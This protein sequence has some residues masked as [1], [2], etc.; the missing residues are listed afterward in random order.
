[1][2]Q[3]Q[4]VKRQ[5]SSSKGKLTTW[6]SALVKQAKRPVTRAPYPS[7]D[8]AKGVVTDSGCPGWKE[9]DARQTDEQSRHQE[10]ALARPKVRQHQQP[11]AKTCQKPAPA[12]NAPPVGNGSLQQMKAGKSGTAQRSQHEKGGL[13]RPLI[14][15]EP[16]E[17]RY[18]PPGN[19]PVRLQEFDRIDAEANQQNQE[20]SHTDRAPEQQLVPRRAGQQK[21]GHAEDDRQPGGVWLGSQHQD[22][23]DGVE[24]PGPLSLGFSEQHG[25]LP[26]QQPCEDQAH[27]VVPP[28]RSRHHRH[29]LAAEAESD[30]L[31]NRKA[32]P[33]ELMGLDR[34]GRDRKGGRQMQKRGPVGSKKAEGEPA[35]STK[36]GRRGQIE[37]L[38]RLLALQEAIR[39]IDQDCKIISPELLIPEPVNQIPEGG[40]CQHSGQD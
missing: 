2:R 35:S 36:D 32:Q 11:R 27:G 30:G 29:R 19:A 15:R 21:N 12:E 22:Q 25:T 28:V 8:H 14:L 38:E 10:P 3:G 18:C 40:T 24:T 34:E 33:C 4:G 17:P 37:I 39:G 9:D 23:Q 16:G 6:S 1:M 31:R 5:G 20:S 26:D 13:N 7:R